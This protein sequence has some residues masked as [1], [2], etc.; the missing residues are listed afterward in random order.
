MKERVQEQLSTRFELL[1]SKLPTNLQTEF[2]Q[3]CYF[4]GGCIYSLWN[5]QEPKDWDVFCTSKLF[6][7]KLK[8]WFEMT[9]L[10]TFI[11]EYAITF[12]PY[13]FVLA[14]VGD[15]EDVVAEFDFMHNMFYFRHGKVCTLSDW[16]YLDSNKLKFNEERARDVAS[17]I[18]RVPKFVARGMEISK[19][20]M[21]M[22][23]D[24]AT[25]FPAV[26]SERKS[27]KKIR[28]DR[29]Y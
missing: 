23:L 15:P 22:M 9:K 24:K 20:E 26:V 19:Q 25:A 14:F 4:A 1:K 8:S 5:E 7:K 28:K 6:L 27:I 12:P 10:H 11:S 17:T 29:S 16:S 21:A 2:E 18:T 13:Q 3:T